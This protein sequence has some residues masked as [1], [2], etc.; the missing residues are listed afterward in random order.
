M[1]ITHEQAQRLIQLELDHG[2]NVQNSTLLVSHLRLCPGCQAY[3]NEMNELQDLLSPLLKR[4]WAT[5]PVP[6]SIPSLL[7]SN[8]KISIGH[9][10]TIR[11]T[12]VSL[13]I[14][15]MFFTVW[16]FMFSSPMNA[17]PVPLAPP[18][19]TP[20][21]QTARAV[22]LTVTSQNCEMIFYSVQRGDTIVGIAEKFSTTEEEIRRANHLAQSSL[23]SGMQLLIPV[24]S[25]TP[26]GTFQA[27]AFTSTITPFLQPR[28]STPGG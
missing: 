23:D 15:A 28:L 17:R 11:S 27:A 25:P 2:L 16:Q 22:S 6:L 8:R 4:K 14:L 1:Q 21:S 12:A 7:E 13:M 9:L 3:R 26:T 20:A 10:L 5:Q 19:P 24:C 18:I